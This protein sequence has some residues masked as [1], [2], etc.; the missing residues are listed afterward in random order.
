[1]ASSVNLFPSP[2]NTKGSLG[3]MRTSLT[4]ELV[5]SASWVSKGLIFGGGFSLELSLMTRRP[6]FVVTCSGLTMVNQ[7]FQIG[8]STSAA[9]R[10]RCD[11]ISNT[12]A[13]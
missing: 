2:A 3:T 11:V 12:L 7:C 5:A 6:E 8:R 4:T 10:H 1:M 9:V 13:V